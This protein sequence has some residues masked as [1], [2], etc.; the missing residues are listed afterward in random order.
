MEGYLRVFWSQWPVWWRSW[1]HVGDW[2]S[3]P[4]SDGVV[5]V[6]ARSPAI[7]SAVREW[8]APELKLETQRR[9]VSD[10]VVGAVWEGT[11]LGG[12]EAAELAKFA[13]SLPRRVPLVALLDFRDARPSRPLVPSAPPRFS[14]SRST[15]TTCAIVWFRTRPD[16]RACRSTSV[17][18]RRD[19][20]DLTQRAECDRPS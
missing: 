7:A 6:A 5:V 16:R 13:R 4:K 17:A 11:Q 8:L 10:P 1:N 19:A 14:A 9:T 15:V 18:L 2:P 3:L 12:L 20:T